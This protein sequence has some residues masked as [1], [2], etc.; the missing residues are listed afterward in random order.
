MP[1]TMLTARPAMR[2]AVL[3]IPALPLSADE[4]AMSVLLRLR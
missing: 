3:A 1:V 2:I 4:D